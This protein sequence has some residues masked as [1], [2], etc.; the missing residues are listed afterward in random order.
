MKPNLLGVAVVLLLAAVCALAA[1][2]PKLEIKHI[3]FYCHPSLGDDKSLAET[4]ALMQRAARAGY[5]GIVLVENK[6]Q[7]W[8]QVT[9]QYLENMK[10]FR[11]ACRDNKLACVAA[12]TP[13]GYA[14]DLLSNDPDLAEGMPVVDA[15]FVVKDG[16]LVPDDPTTLVNGTF[17]EVKDGKP[18]GWD[19]DMPGQITFVDTEVRHNGKPTLRLEDP[20]KHDPQ[21]AHCRAWQVVPVKPFRYYHLSCWVKTENFRPTGDTRLMALGSKGLHEGVPLNVP[22]LDGIKETQDWTLYDKTFNTQDFT[23]AVI[24]V[25]SWSAKS[26]KIWYGDVRMEPAGLVDLLRRE[27]TPLKATSPDGKTVYEEGKDLPEVKD[28]LLGKFPYVGGYNWHEQPTIT[29]PAGSRLRDG[30]KVLLSYY[31]TAIMY[32]NDQ[33]PICMSEPKT[34]DWIRW[35][36]AGVH[37][38]LNPDYYFMEHDEIRMQGWDASCQRTGK[39][40]GGILADSIRKCTEIIQKE[41]PGKGIFVWSDMFDPYANAQKTGYY[42]LC[43]GEGPW[44]GSWE[45]LPKEVGLINWNG[46][47]AESVKFFA[48][49]GHPQIL[50]QVNPQAVVDW[51]RKSAP[52]SPGIVGVIYVTWSNDFSNLE[53]Y[54]QAV[55]QFEKEYNGSK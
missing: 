46:G 19:M 17:E 18:V 16:K 51:L 28:P 2:K 40:C 25:G 9:P 23:E 11:Q 31:H 50:S 39:T 26:G 54:A 15:P 4:I 6:M 3:W 30:D 33:V 1:E 36:I 38:N 53:K 21:Y 45:G 43:R 7:R 29:I 32:Y 10:K 44:Y 13:L 37:K 12:V 55:R 24:Y 20:Q 47:N 49:E 5:T 34:Y 48:T 8:N 14:N 42:Y 35:H 41:D 22:E 52:E 27:G